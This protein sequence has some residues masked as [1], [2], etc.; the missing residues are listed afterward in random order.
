MLTSLCATGLIGMVLIK[1]WTQVII[2]TPFPFFPQGNNG[3]S[4]LNSALQSSPSTED[5]D[6]LD[7]II[8]LLL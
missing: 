5:P 6:R 2:L 7:L 4:D 8:F 3:D 1:H